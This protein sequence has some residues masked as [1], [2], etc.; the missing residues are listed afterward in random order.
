MLQLLGKVFYFHTHLK[1]R[2][3]ETTGR[4]H[5]LL[6]C[7]IEDLVLHE[8]R[9]HDEGLQFVGHASFLTLHLVKQS[10][11]SEPG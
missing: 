2:R 1:G 11:D 10:D 3:I 4:L 5:H 8:V 6:A 9:V 7:F